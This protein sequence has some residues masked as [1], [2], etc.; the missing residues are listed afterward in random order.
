MEFE[1]K[2]PVRV[3]TVVVSTQHSDRVSQSEV[4]EFVRFMMSQADVV[5]AV[6]YVPAPFDVYTENRAR[7]EAMPESGSDA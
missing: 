7:L 3:H 4:R 1:G 2:R 5:A 6:G